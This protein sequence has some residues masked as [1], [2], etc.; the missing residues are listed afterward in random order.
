[1]RKVDSVKIKSLFGK[2]GFVKINNLFKE[3]LIDDLLD[4]LKKKVWR[5]KILNLNIAVN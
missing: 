2:G 1:M 4:M 5:I 3:E